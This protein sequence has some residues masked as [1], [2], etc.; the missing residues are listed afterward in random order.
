MCTDRLLLVG[1]IPLESA[2]E[3]MTL[4]A[5][6][7]GGHL[8]C[9]PDGEVLDR[10][11]WVV[12]MWFQVFSAHPAFEVEQRPAAAAGH[13]KLIPTGLEDMWRFKLKPGVT[14]IEFDEPGWRL[15]YAKDAQNSYAIFSAMKR[16]GKIPEQ[17]RFQGSL[18]SVNSVCNPNILGNDEAQ[19]AIVRAGFEKAMAAEARKICEIIPNEELA[20]QYDCSFEVTDVNGGLELVTGTPLERNLG[21]FEA[22]TE[23][24]A[25]DVQLGFHLC[26]GTFGGWPRFAPESL[27]P[28]VELANGIKQATGRS[29][30]WIHIPALDTEDEG[31]YASLADLALGH[32]RVYL[33]LV[34]TM[35]TFEARYR[36]ARKFLPD[37]G[38]GAYCGMGRLEPEAVPGSFKDHVKA[39]EIAR[40]VS[41]E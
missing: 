27:G 37:F 1:S 41:A 40:R 35:E 28:T 21:Q 3:V 2:S 36:V 20:I 39:V 22:L 5:D 38:L 26:F 9:M 7:L 30:D 17:T 34:H 19:L 11:F 15:G 33:G 31:F 8:D 13:E 24:V 10:R 14:E 23:A 6:Q 4:A 32:T 18:P 12:R 25:D 16:E 29:I